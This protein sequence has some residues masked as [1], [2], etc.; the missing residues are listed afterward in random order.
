MAEIKEH[1]HDSCMLGFSIPQIVL[2][3]TCI[4]LHVFLFQEKST[5]YFVGHGIWAGGI[6][7]MINYSILRF[8][9][10]YDEFAKR[11]FI[12]LCILSS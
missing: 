10:Y 6:V 8:F 1:F 3:L 2:G 4:I 12:A 11:G 9:R 7:S 5:L